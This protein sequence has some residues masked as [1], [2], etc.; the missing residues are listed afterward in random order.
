MAD[1]VKKG[2]PDL[3]VETAKTLTLGVVLQPRF[4]KNFSATV[5]YYDIDM[6][7]V[8]SSVEPQTII[9]KCMDA[10][11]LDNN[12][13]DLVVRDP[14]TNNLVSVIKQNIN[15]ARRKTSGIDTEIDY[16][17]NLASWGWGSNAGT[18]SI[19]SIWTRLFENKYTPDPD[20]PNSVTD[21]VG[22][23]GFPKLKGRTAFNYTRDKLSLGWTSRF[24]SGM[25][26]T[27]TITPE[28]YAPYKTKP[29]AYDD[30]YISY[31]LKPNMNLSAGL[32]NALNKQPP[33]YP[34]AEAG[35]AYFGD[36]GWQAGVYDVI[37]RT[38]WINLRFTR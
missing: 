28:D 23:F 2:N 30:I 8:I 35:G 11:T 22:I 37:G 26:Q 5:D 12:Y 14:V 7:N 34:G 33:R 15:L 31:W 24:Y 27:V 29:I 19:N 20:N 18:L 25:R 13:C 4:M 17:V 10:P 6:S 9:N 21:T 1:V 32:S 3:K 38:G 16:S 36:E